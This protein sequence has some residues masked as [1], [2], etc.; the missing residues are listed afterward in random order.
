MHKVKSPIQ[1]LKFLLLTCTFAFLLLPCTF[2]C[3]AQDKIVAIVNNDIITQKDLIDFIN[4]T[5]MQLAEDYQG[6][7]LES[8]IQS[9]KINLLDRLIE[10]RLI[11]Q[12]AKKNNIKAD[13]NRVKAKIDEIKKRYNQDSE[14]QEVLARQGLVQADIEARIKEQ[15]LMYNIIDIKVKSRI[16]VNPTEVTDFY[17]K[18]LEALKLSEIR[19]LEVISIKDVNLASEISGNLKNGQRLED[20]IKKYS[21]S[22]DKLRVT[23]K[24]E[25]RQ[26][27]EKAV[28]K[29]KPQEISGP[30]KVQETYYIFKLD[31]IISAR[32]PSLSEVQDKIHGLIFNQKMQE[33]L[34]R[35]LG[36][37]KKNAYIKIS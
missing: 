30:I 35:W 20:L 4:F 25:L 36:E 3:F 1:K 29:L 34:T 31:N 17:D 24:G 14:F 16:V 28:F 8:K 37:L 26:D 7:K 10:D 12:E 13:E 27:I 21:L 11:L 22:V 9:M 5:R 18:N 2:Y 23:E 19:E 6:E 33:E 15:L 32:Q